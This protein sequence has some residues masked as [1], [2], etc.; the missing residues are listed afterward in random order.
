MAVDIN[1]Y[2]QKINELQA[3]A[4]QAKKDLIVA[5]TNLENLQ[6]RKDE[7]TQECEQY[8]GVKITDVPQLLAEKQKELEGIMTRLDE[9]DLSDISKLGEPQ[10]EQLKA[11]MKDFNIQEETA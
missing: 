8:A 7:L 10:L 3:S 2:L 6:K 1:Q 11:I 9:I 4:D 5:E